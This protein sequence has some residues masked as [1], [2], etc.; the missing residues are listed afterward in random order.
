M[1]TESEPVLL[2]T[3]VLVYALDEESPHH[4]PSRAVVE[5]AANGDGRHCLTSQI[6]AEFFS[7]VTNPRRVTKPRTAHEAVEAIDAF[8]AMPG[9]SL[10][11]TGPG[12]VSRWLAMIRLAPVAGA[13]VFDVQLAATALESGVSKI[14]TFNVVHFERIDGIEVVAP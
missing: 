12:V 14:C 13:N 1:T 3:N 4:A 11:P 5:R 10:L 2:D 6:L 7:I 9:I 8:L